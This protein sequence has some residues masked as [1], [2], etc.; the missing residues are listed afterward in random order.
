MTTHA[1]AIFTRIPYSPLIQRIRPD[2]FPFLI[3]FE[4]SLNSFCALS[5]ICTRIYMDFSEAGVNNCLS[6]WVFV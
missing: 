3:R 5:P 1:Y 2:L 4:C 6:F